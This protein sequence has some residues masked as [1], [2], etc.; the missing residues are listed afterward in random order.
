VTVASPGMD[1]T[2]DDDDDNEEE[3]ED[4]DNAGGKPRA[5]T[6]LDPSDTVRKRLLLTFVDSLLQV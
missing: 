6:V 3:E 4:D 2:D 5:G 1:N